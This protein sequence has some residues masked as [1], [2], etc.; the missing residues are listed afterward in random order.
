V[1]WNGSPSEGTL[2]QR[3]ST[4]AQAKVA[5]KPE[6]KPEMARAGIKGQHPTATQSRAH[7][8]QLFADFD[9]Q[10]AQIQKDMNDRMGSLFGDVKDSFY[11][12]AMEVSQKA[13]DSHVYV[14][15]DL[16]D[17]DENSVEVNIDDGMIQIKG[18]KSVTSENQNEN[19]QAVS[20]SYSS[21]SRAFP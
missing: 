14:K 2:A 8:D 10:F 20:K 13:D 17:V 6:N 3:S 7:V 16:G 5:P 11:D 12:N 15:I 9:Q 19:G 21:F 4:V 18:E 1:N